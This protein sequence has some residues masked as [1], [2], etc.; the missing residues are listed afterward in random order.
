MFI[1]DE[2]EDFKSKIPDQVTF[3]SKTTVENEIRSRCLI[4][5]NFMG[6]EV[7]LLCLK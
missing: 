3:S 5:V 2:E 1:S 6:Y 4:E 7:C